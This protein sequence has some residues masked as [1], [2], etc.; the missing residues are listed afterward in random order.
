MTT[1]TVETLRAE[2]RALATQDAALC[3]DLARLQQQAASM[4]GDAGAA[5]D[6]QQARRGI[7]A[8]LFRSGRPAK[9]AAPELASIDKQEQAA[10]LRAANAQAAMDVQREIEADIE[11][12]RAT[13][14][15]RVDELAQALRRAEFEAA[16]AEFETVHGP[17][18]VAALGELNR[19]LG[20]VYGAVLAR[21]RMHARAGF[22]ARYSDGTAMH[23][24]AP[25]LPSL[26]VSLPGLQLEDR[27]RC[28]LDLLGWNYSN[29]TLDF[30]A[31]LEREAAALVAQWTADTTVQASSAGAT[32]GHHG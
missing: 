22:E 31:D 21:D 17:A 23:T 24:P 9:D 29:A 28:R 4:T 25:A 1:N 26:T 20:K 13:I 32:G 8:G 14:R 19:A 18:C 7:F 2:L 12:K 15:A 10:R 16:R 6:L 11:A 27:L 5:N 3:D 30:S